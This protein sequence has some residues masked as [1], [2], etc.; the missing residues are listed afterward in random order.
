MLCS[1]SGGRILRR[2]HLLGPFC[3]IWR[4][5]AVPIRFPR[6]EACTSWTLCGPAYPKIHCFG[7]AWQ[8]C[9][10]LFRAG[11]VNDV[12]WTISFNS[13]RFRLSVR[14]APL[15]AAP[16]ALGR[17]KC[18]SEQCS[19]SLLAKVADSSEHARLAWRRD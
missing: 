1:N 8:R 5:K 7:P 4:K 15:K 19:R 13:A 9:R 6:F 11:T 3:H 16:F 18:T 14:P 10:P 17:T 2:L 12:S